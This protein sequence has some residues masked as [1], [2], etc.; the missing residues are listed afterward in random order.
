[1]VF[2]YEYLWLDAKGNLRGK[3][4]VLSGDK[5][6]DLKDLPVWNYD[7]SSTE[8]AEGKDS[9]VLIKPQA[10]FKDPFHK[11][12]EE[13]GVTGAYLVMCDTYLPSMKPHPTNS[14]FPA[15]VTFK[16]FKH[17]KPRYGIEQEFF[18]KHR[19]VDGKIAGRVIGFGEGHVMKLTPA[20][21]GQYYC[22][23]GSNNAFGRDF[24]ITAFHNCLK[25]G[26]N[27]TGMNAEVAPGQWEFQVCADGIA[28]AD[29]LYVMRYI[30][31]RTGESFDYTV[32]FHPKPLHSV[33]W[34]GSGCHTNFSTEPMREEGG[35]EVI[36]Q[37]L[38]SLSKYQDLCMENYG[39]DNNLRMTGELETS[40]PSEFSWGVANRGCSIRVPNQ[41]VTEGKGYFE[42]RRPASNMDPYVVTSLLLELT[43]PDE[44]KPFR[45]SAE[46]SS[47]KSAEESV[48][49]SSEKQSI[50]ENSLPL[51]SYDSVPDY[52]VT[53]NSDNLETCPVNKSEECLS[54]CSTECVNSSIN[55]FDF[56]S[57]LNPFDNDPLAKTIGKP[58]TGTSS[59]FDQLVTPNTVEKDES[60]ETKENEDDIIDAVTPTSSSGSDIAEGLANTP[61]AKT[62]V[63][64]L[65]INFQR[66]SPVKTSSSDKESEEES[67][68]ESEKQDSEE[69]EQQVQ[70]ETPEESSQETT[71]STSFMS[72][73][74][75]F[76]NIINKKE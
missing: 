16:A 13:T 58:G 25:A 66:E 35:Y 59:L 56:S 15:N 27:L 64:P 54:Q 39:V 33:E 32:D 43:S 20:P 4:K 52:V 60:E 46:E 7:G 38:E 18:I 8:Q 30:L 72:Y 3:T 55:A 45:E 76:N 36:K 19:D 24:I 49:E 1:M 5:P 12:G 26:L 41:T 10:I 51:P 47:E 37:A 65:N 29:Q 11:T 68:H 71:K 40:N 48:E 53:S 44:K 28:A 70:Q 50:A 63:V 67:E 74:N 9:E 62:D 31:A 6:V 34:N 23:V 61:R 17:L 2:L 22:S 21:Q 69:K 73:T 75:Y 42:D 57:E 14:R